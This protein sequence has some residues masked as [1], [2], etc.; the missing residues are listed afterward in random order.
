MK[1]ERDLLIAI[2]LIL[3]L[4]PTAS[5]GLNITDSAGNDITQITKT[6]VHNSQ[7]C[8]PIFYVK[9]TEAV[10]ITN[11]NIT[12]GKVTNASDLIDINITDTT[13]KTILPGNTTNYTIGGPSCNYDIP[14]YLTAGT[15]TVPINVSGVNTTNGSF[16]DTINA[17]ITVNETKSLSPST[18]TLATSTSPGSK[19]NTTFT[20]T[21]T[22]NA[23]LT[24]IA[25]T[26]SST[27]EDSDNDTI[28]LSITA[29]RS[30][31]TLQP[32]QVATIT[33]QATPSLSINVGSYTSNI[34][35]NNS[36]GASATL[37]YTVTIIQ[38]FCIKGRI[39]GFFTIEIKEPDAGDDFYPNDVIPVE[40]RVKNTDDDEHDVVIEAD[41][42][43]ATSGKFL[44]EGADTTEDIADDTSEDYALSM[45]VPLDITESHSYRLYAKAYLEDEEE[46]QCNEDYI[47]IDLKR[48]T[49]A[50]LIDKLETPSSVGCGETFDVTTTIIDNGKKDEDVKLRISNTE[51]K[52]NEEK[53]LSIDREDKKKVILSPQIP[54]DASEKNY[55]FT[56]QAFYHLSS[57]TYQDST[58]K[59]V[60]ITVKGNCAAAVT[61]TAV[62]SSEVL[63]QPYANEQAGIKFTLFNT[64][65]AKTTYTLSVSGY[66]DWAILNKIEPAVLTIDAGSKG[67]AFVYLTPLE[68]VSGE[69][70]FTVKALYG[71]KKTESEVRINVKERLSAPSVYQ[72]LATR[73]SNLSGF[74]LMTVNVVLVIAVILT[75]IW[76]L[77]VRK[78]Y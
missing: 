53:T 70:K 76:I 11:M 44:D 64:G 34:I 7:I 10:N 24:N 2:A 65:T 20:I 73:L 35:V 37:Q 69:K 3:F 45:K 18:T 77:R 51:L 42:F 12:I 28:T 72:G 40:V 17:V 55:T 63:A 14:Q 33:V 9:N 4:M 22:G 29:D 8:L 57:D 19:V 27:L 66:A 26:Q 48:E 58:S 68:N 56:V 78:S 50:I 31:A 39:G 46:K 15:Y 41:L 1:R 54:K 21:N 30:L 25:F 43:D 59:T 6:A 16:S 32:G 36:E 60:Q 61:T 62:L 47:S 71:D 75:V 5:A 74:D 23:N 52:I 67:E 38:S 13:K 49:H